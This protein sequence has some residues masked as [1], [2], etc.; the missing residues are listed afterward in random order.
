MENK[1]EQNKIVFSVISKLATAGGAIVKYSDYEVLADDMQMV[2]QI[3]LRRER[4]GTI[5]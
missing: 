5:R 2:D 3:Y 4:D 1:A